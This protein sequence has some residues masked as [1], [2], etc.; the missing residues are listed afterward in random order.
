MSVREKGRKKIQQE[1]STQYKVTDPIFMA[2]LEHIHLR[3][4]RSYPSKPPPLSTKTWEEVRREKEERILRARREGALSTE[5]T[6]EINKEIAE[7]ATEME[8]RKQKYAQYQRTKQTADYKVP[9]TDPIPVPDLTN[10]NKR[11]K[12]SHPQHYQI[13][14]C[15]NM[16]RYQ[17]M[18]INGNLVCGQ[19]VPHQD[20]QTKGTKKRRLSQK[21]HRE[22][23]LPSKIICLQ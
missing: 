13:L 2:D 12:V 23:L 20:C 21:F 17:D 18:V 3:Q 6:Q 15:P 1:T 9:K 10:L 5:E 22:I 19:Q 11:K 14:M 8:L 4:G 7:K 16:K